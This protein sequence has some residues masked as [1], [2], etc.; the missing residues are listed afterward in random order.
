MA[1]TEFTQLKKS[2]ELEEFDIDDLDKLLSQ[3]TAEEIDELNG[4]FDPDNTFLPPSER[5]KPQTTKESTGPFN[6]KKLLAFLEKKAKEEKDWEN[7]I[8]YVKKEPGSGDHVSAH[9]W[10]PKE[11][12]KPKTKEQEAIDTEWDDVLKQASEEEL[13]DLAA[14]LGFHGMLNQTQFYA[15]EA[16]EKIEGGGF[17]GVAKAETLKSVPFE[18][19]NTTD[20][21]DS[22][23]RIRDND[24][25][26]KHLNLNNIKNISHERLA[27]IFE[28][29]KTNTNLDTL[30]M[31]SVA[32]T[33]RVA[34]KLVEALPE[35]K[36]LT[37]LNLE[38]NFLSGEMIVEILKAI[39]K[40]QTVVEL[41]VANQKPEVLGNKVETQITKLILENDKIKR[42]GISFEFADARIRVTKKLEDNLDEFRKRRIS[43]KGTA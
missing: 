1:T 7:V 43:D 33:D 21:E 26:L 23:K 41:R 36:T 3:L 40:N 38:S 27:E 19:P 24:P 5:M 39:N 31:S 18:P 34:K 28:G 15:S 17:S 10:K 37:N 30:E 35:N 42:L 4:D 13:V 22:I 11:P 25:K 32:L 8:A 12:A 29:L 9:P 20:V 14:V 16:D 6:R 2:K